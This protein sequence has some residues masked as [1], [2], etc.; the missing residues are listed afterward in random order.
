MIELEK[1][2]VEELKQWIDGTDEGDVCAGS[3]PVHETVK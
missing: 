1:D 3:I 2:R